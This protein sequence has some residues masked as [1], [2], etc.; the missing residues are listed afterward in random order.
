MRS[1]VIARNCLSFL[2]GCTPIGNG[3]FF[4]F[5]EAMPMFSKERIRE[6]RASMVARGNWK[7]VRRLAKIAKFNKLASSDDATEKT[8][9]YGGWN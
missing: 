7:E 1:M 4:I 2:D 9:L 5:E 6:M 8:K 3:F